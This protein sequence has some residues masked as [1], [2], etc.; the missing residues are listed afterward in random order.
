MS[1][2]AES[3][4]KILWRQGPE[5]EAPYAW[6]SKVMLERVIE[7][8]HVTERSSALSV[9]N[10]LCVLSSDNESNTFEAPYGL[11]AHKCQLHKNTVKSRIPELEKAGVIV[12]TRRRVPG[13]KEYAPHIYRLVSSRRQIKGRGKTASVPRPTTAGGASL[14]SCRKGVV[15]EEHTTDT[16]HRKIDTPPSAATASSLNASDDAGKTIAAGKDNESGQANDMLNQIMK[17]LPSHF[18]NSFVESEVR[19]LVEFGAQAEQIK[20]YIQR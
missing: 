3:P 10:A 14:S 12:V 6:V 8:P 20:G 17:S 9:Y 4:P 7:S 16:E 11:I 1:E 13:T 19:E 18:Q 5:D 2:A 15:S